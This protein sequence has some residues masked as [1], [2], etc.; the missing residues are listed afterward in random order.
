MTIR[1]GHLH[2]NNAAAW[3]SQKSG[4]L[5][6][7]PS[8]RERVPEARWAP[9][10]SKLGQSEQT[11]EVAAVALRETT[12]FV[13]SVFTRMD[14]EGDNIVFAKVGLVKIS[15][16]PCGHE[17]VVDSSLEIFNLQSF[18]LA[19]AL[20]GDG[21]CEELQAKHIECPLGSCT[22]MWLCRS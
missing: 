2:Q 8:S 21:H 4:A 7:R 22:P 18:I 12:I 3:T 19:L 17:E 14:L 16:Q 5:P 13:S 6:A 20:P 1:H 9:S 11:S 10:F 15:F